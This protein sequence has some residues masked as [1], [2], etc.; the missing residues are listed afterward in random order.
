MNTKRHAKKLC[1]PTVKKIRL[2]EDIKKLNVRIRKHPHVCV[3]V[4]VCVRVCMCVCKMIIHIHQD[5]T[6]NNKCPP[7]RGVLRNVTK[8]VF[9]EYVWRSHIS[10]QN[11]VS[12]PYLS[13]LILNFYRCVTVAWDRHQLWVHFPLVP[14]HCPLRLSHQRLRLSGGKL[15]SNT[16]LRRLGPCV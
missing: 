14:R 1:N 7:S 2:H 6:G 8:F 10:L 3:Y 16:S 9:I 4:R 15:R 13:H 5:T 11:V 12:D